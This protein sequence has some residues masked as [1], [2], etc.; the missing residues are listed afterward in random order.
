MWSWSRPMDVCFV[1]SE[2]LLLGRYDLCTIFVA[3]LKLPDP[4]TLVINTQASRVEVPQLSL[5][6]GVL[7]FISVGGGAHRNHMCI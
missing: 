7:H 2:S 1:F 6:I 5:I 4:N 3:N